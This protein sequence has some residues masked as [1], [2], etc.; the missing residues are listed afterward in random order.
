MNC[1]ICGYSQFSRT[2]ILWDKLI[3]EWKLSPEE[4]DYIDRQQGEACKRCDSNLRSIALANAIRAF[5]GT[6]YLLHKLVVSPLYKNATLLEINAAGNL[7]N[8]LNRFIGYQFGAYPEIDIHKLP[9]N[10]GTFDLVVHSDTLE[11][12]EDPV[13]A[14][15]E[16]RRVLK[17][18]GGLCFTVPIVVGRLSRSR[19][20][21]PKSYHGTDETTS[22]DLIVRTEFGADAW[23]YL[24]EAGFTDVSIHSFGYPAGVA[25]LARNGWE[26]WPI[27]VRAS[28]SEHLPLWR[29][30]RLRELFGLR[31]NSRAA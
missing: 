28:I 26:R 30:A 20:M 10:D 21:L 14:L 8:Y 13:H 23:K 4:A 12:V 16:C 19:A 18:E 2:R 5:F 1:S 6:P 22:D 27:R 29:L 24:M 31:D 17:P 25:L 11:H 3:E 7:T 15:R 9:Y